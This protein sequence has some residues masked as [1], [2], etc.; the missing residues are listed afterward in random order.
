MAWLYFRISLPQQGTPRGQTCFISC[1]LSQWLSLPAVMFSICCNMLHQIFGL[2]FC[3]WV[4]LLSAAIVIERGFSSENQTLNLLMVLLSSF[5][6]FG[7]DVLIRTAVFLFY[8]F[9]VISQVSDLNLLWG[10]HSKVIYRQNWHKFE[11]SPR[12]MHLK[13]G[14]GWTYQI[15]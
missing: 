7:P 11:F 2:G 13:W 10:N 15:Q 8:S 3:W 14:C 6:Q 4:F 1:N 5:T 12:G 9:C